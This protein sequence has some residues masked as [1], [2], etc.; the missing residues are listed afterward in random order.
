MAFTAVAPGLCASGAVRKTETDLY[1]RDFKTSNSDISFNSI[2]TLCEDSIGFI[3]V[4]TSDGLN[5]FDGTKFRTFR[6]EDLGLSSSYIVSL[7]QQGDRLWIGTDNGVAYYD[8]TLDSFEPFMQKSD[9][10]TA[11]AGKATVICGDREG[12]VWFGVNE[13]GIFKYEPASGRLFNY[14]HGKGHRLPAN[15]RA[16]YFGRDS[17]CLLSL[18][19]HN[20]YRADWT[21]ERIT[22]VTIDGDTSLFANDNILG[23]AAASDSTIY[24]VSVHKGLVEFKPDGKSRILSGEISAHEPQGMALGADG[25]IWLPTMN[26]LYRYSSTDGSVKLY[27]NEPSDR[28]SLS[29]S[30]ILTAMEDRNGGI[31]CG[32]FSKGLSYSD[33]TAN[34][35]KRTRLLTAGSQRAAKVQSLEVDRRGN[36]WCATAYGGLQRTDAVTGITERIM[37]SVI[38]SE[39]FD[40]CLSG[41]EVWVS[42]LS[43]IFRINPE[44]GDYRF[45]DRLSR[46]ISFS[47]NKHVGIRTTMSGDVLVL[48][49]LGVF[50]YDSTSNSFVPFRGTGECYVTDMAEDDYGHLWFST[51]AHGLICYDP[52]KQCIVSHWRYKPGEKRSLPTDKLQSVTVDNNGRVWATSFGAGIIRFDTDSTFTV[53]DR[54]SLGEEL[55]TD[56]AYQVLQDKS[57]KMWATTSSGLLTF[58]PESNCAYTFR[59]R[60]GLLNEDF[61]STHGTVTHDG[62][63][64]LCSA[65]GYI[66]FR[67]QLL[68]HSDETPRLIINSLSINGQHITVKT[69]KS[70]LRQAIDTTGRISLAYDQTDIEFDISDLMFTGGHGYDVLTYRLRNYDKEWRKLPSDG[71][72]SFPRLQAG[73]YVLEFERLR[74]DSNG[75]M[76]SSIAHHP[77]QIHVAQI[78][79]KTKWAWMLYAIL[80]IAAISLLWQ[81]IYR[82]RI[83]RA[84]E[85]QRQAAKEQEIEAYNEKVAMI[86]FVANRLRAPLALIRNP[87]TNILRSGAE[88]QLADDLM[89]ISNG[90]DKLSKV[91]A[92]FAVFNNST[93][94]ADENDGADDTAGDTCPDEQPLPDA[95][96]KDDGNLT[97]THRIMLIETAPDM[98]AE[99]KERLKSRHRVVVVRS[100]EVALELMQKNHVDLLVIPDKI[101]GQSAASLC[102]TMAGRTDL[103]VVPVLVVSQSEN[104]DAALYAVKAGAAQVITHP[105]TAVYVE[106]CI[107]TLLRRNDDMRARPASMMVLPGGNLMQLSDAD[108][109]FL[110]KLDAIVMEN[111]GDSDFSNEQLA[112]LLCMSKSTLMRK[113][114]GVLETTPKDYILD[115]RLAL[116]AEM[117]KRPSC[118]VNEVCYAVGFNTPSYFAKCFKRAYGMLPSE[119]RDEG[120]ADSGGEGLQPH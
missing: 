25:V 71:R 2:N 16:I 55:A 106:A 15:V 114:K 113:M 44:T 62:T 13:H 90:A 41:D 72:I 91:L 5:R 117:L 119:Y 103:Q 81:R 112:K 82:R 70:P 8:Y 31:W 10:G 64:Y 92:D 116:A 39:T 111:I 120:N 115:K 51:F 87:L 86:S 4:G 75:K 110:K 89:V 98:F 36:V 100:A 26:G 45:Y 107:D 102:E 74:Q 79:Y 29:D 85:R 43:G 18:Y 69:K 101:K 24:A 48:T 35:F 57:G 30:Y 93:E 76:L 73:D 50:R 59:S 58:D 118:R 33:P 32:T 60:H 54:A 84:E 53:F 20:L 96:A 77:L 34:R 78:F 61:A 21:H 109:D 12:N 80:A 56:V 38:P 88:G 99:I 66:S 23:L 95:D 17:E 1:F 47:E 65:D 108:A 63:I 42:A 14:F 104:R 22:P 19:F 83:R 67:P 94:T 7:Y 49:T 97:G 40:V 46:N 3:W 68:K 52:E 27:N 28:Y 37:P 9:K 105:F 11:I 6:K